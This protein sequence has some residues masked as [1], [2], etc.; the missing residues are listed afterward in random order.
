MRRIIT[1]NKTLVFRA[2]KRYKDCNFQGPFI[3]RE[4]AMFNLESLIKDKLNFCCNNISNCSEC[5]S[6]VYCYW[7][8]QMEYLR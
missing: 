1:N 8:E 3:V 7:G 5:S 4:Q 2:I 6:F